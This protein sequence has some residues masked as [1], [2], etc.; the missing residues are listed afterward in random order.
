M[1]ASLHAREAQGYLVFLYKQRGSQYPCDSEMYRACHSATVRGEYLIV[2]V[3]KYKFRSARLFVCGGCL[4]GG[5]LGVDE[6]LGMR[7]SQTCDSPV[8]SVHS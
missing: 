2:G 7:F 5:G 6:Q 3:N 8:F 4:V 1:R